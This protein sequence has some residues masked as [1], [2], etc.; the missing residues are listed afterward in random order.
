ML[1]LQL[2]GSRFLVRALTAPRPELALGFRMLPPQICGSDLLIRD[3]A[4]ERRQRALRF[5]ILPLQVFQPPLLASDEPA[6]LERVFVRHRGRKLY[7][8][9]R[10]LL[11]G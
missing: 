6:Q 8:G 5:G 10:E 7:V 11:R 3:Q 9:S 1:P 4:T 2:R